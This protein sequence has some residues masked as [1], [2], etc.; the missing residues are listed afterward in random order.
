MEF[1]CKLFL[2]NSLEIYSSMPTSGP[3][4]TQTLPR[5]SQGFAQIIYDA[6]PDLSLL[7]IFWWH[8]SLFAQQFETVLNFIIEIRQNCFEPPL[9]VAY[10]LV[11]VTLSCCA[12]WAY[13]IKDVPK[14]ILNNS[15]INTFLN[16]F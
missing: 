3:T 16:T 7:T 8:P 14:Y 6:L 10:N 15:S 9:I 2:L 11:P 1:E 12:K 5:L 13:N 4:L